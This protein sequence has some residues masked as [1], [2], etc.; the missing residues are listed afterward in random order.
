MSFIRSAPLVYCEIAIPH[1]SL[2]YTMLEL[3]KLKA[4]HIVDLE[5]APHINRP[6]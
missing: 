3:V 6:F 1:E 2:Y 5:E 4:F